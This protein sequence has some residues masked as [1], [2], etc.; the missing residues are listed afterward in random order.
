MEEDLSYQFV[1]NFLNT[2]HHISKYHCV[3]EDSEAT[4][5]LAAN[6]SSSHIF[7]NEKKKKGPTICTAAH[8]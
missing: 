6:L 5:G 4:L 8:V 7:F 3:L 1:A 2:K